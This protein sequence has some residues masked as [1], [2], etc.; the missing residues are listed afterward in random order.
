MRATYPRRVTT[1][2]VYG[3]AKQFR[4]KLRARVRSGH[5]L[6][7]EL[8]GTRSTLAKGPP[9][10]G[11]PLARSIAFYIGIN[12]ISERVLRWER[13]NRTLVERHLGDAA[14]SEYARR[15]DLG[16]TDKDDLDEA[17]DHI[18]EFIDAHV[19]QLDAILSRLP[20]SRGVDALSTPVALDDLRASRLLDE[21]LIESY[22]HR[23]ST[24]KVAR[25]RAPAIGAAKELVESVLR[26]TLKTLG[27]PT[28]AKNTDMGKLG[29][30]TRVAMEKHSGVAPDPA[31]LATLNRVENA[32]VVFVTEWRNLYGTGHGKAAATKGL[33]A[34]HA[35]FAADLAIAY[36]RLITSTLDDLSLL[37]ATP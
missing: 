21:A 35:R 32:L 3:D 8:E 10:S 13:G 14:G 28:P 23:L 30:L 4:T 9:P 24:T 6:R 7:D 2:R 29:K 37:P 18:G 31:G 5:Q 19:E 27:E 20:T 17:I 1:L 36:T 11:G 12:P 25:G 15:T 33:R 16:W 34:S 22:E 26:A